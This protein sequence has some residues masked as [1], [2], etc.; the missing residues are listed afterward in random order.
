MTEV[1]LSAATM[2]RCKG[3]SFRVVPEVVII[4]VLVSS[5][6]IAGHPAPRAESE[7]SR[8]G[9]SPARPCIL[10][11]LRVYLATLNGVLKKMRKQ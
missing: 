4:V 2:A 9:F 7:E 3:R 11:L 5:M 8:A 10:D 6:A 1:C